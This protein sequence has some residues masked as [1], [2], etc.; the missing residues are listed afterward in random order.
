MKIRHQLFAA[1]VLSLVAAGSAV[2]QAGCVSTNVVI[3][4]GKYVCGTDSGNQCVT[5]PKDA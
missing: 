4:N 1:V 5:C 2:A 3:D